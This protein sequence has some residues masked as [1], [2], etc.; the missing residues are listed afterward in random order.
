M[1]N[2]LR[3]SVLLGTSALPVTADMCIWCD[4]SSCH[5]RASA[6]ARLR[7][8]EQYSSPSPTLLCVLTTKAVQG[9]S[10]V[11]RP[12]VPPVLRAARHLHAPAHGGGRASRELG[13]VCN[14]RQPLAR[15]ARRRSENRTRPVEVRCK[16]AA[17]VGMLLRAVC[18]AHSPC[19]RCGGHLWPLRPSR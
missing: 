12:G 2:Q 18:C 4:F 8:R 15:L 16:N 14:R 3:F 10:G 7:D 9:P 11:R 19:H 5:R 17:R 1:L 13:C 6:S